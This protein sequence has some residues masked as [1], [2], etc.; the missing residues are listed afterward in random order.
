V[1]PHFKNLS[2]RVDR[3]P[4]PPGPRA[5]DRGSANNSPRV[6]ELRTR[7]KGES[8]SARILVV[9]DEKLIR[10]GLCVALKEAGYV[11]EQAGT[12]AEALEAIGRE[13]PDLLL[14]D[15]KLP[16]GS[17]IDV[18][19]AVRKASPRTPV[20]MITAHASVGGAV[21]AMKEGSYDYLGKPFEMDEV[22]QTVGRAL[23]T[24]H[25]REVVAR[26]R[27]D[28]RRESALENIFAFSPAM[29]EV[30]RLIRRIAESEA[31]TILL[32]GES[33]VGKGLVARALHFAGQRWEKPFMNIT[34]TALPEALLESELFGHEKGSFTDAKAQKKGLFELADGGTVFLD[35]IGDLSQGMQ[36]KLLR[37]LEEKAFRRVGGTRDIQVSVRIVAATNKD[38][39]KEVEAGHF[40]SDLY[41]R[42]R[43]IP[44]EI[45]PLRERAEDLMPLAESFVRHFNH[46]LRKSVKGFERDSAELIKKYAW[47]GNVRELRNAIERAVLLTDGEMLSCADLPSEIRHLRSLGEEESRALRL[48]AGGLVLEEL[49]KNMLVQA[50]ARSRGNRTRAAQLLGMNRDQIRYRIEKFGLEEP[51][52]DG[53]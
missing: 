5:G 48:P 51:A 16:D 31:S 3:D 23:E 42:L 25:L 34:C 4:S 44:I 36:G 8:M 41:F 49:E 35:E 9:D 39:T 21:E 6:R 37:V 29:Q 10:W 24:G 53:G 20:V 7:E 38:L 46:E 50:L 27:E 40:R 2:N 26:S 45:P 32:L 22:I 30:V 17:G 52:V 12:A 11:P 47:P 15:Y 1:D 14:L 28:A 19:R 13:V 33:G 18:L 43:V